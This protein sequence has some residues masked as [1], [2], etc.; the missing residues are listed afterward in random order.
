[1]IRNLFGGFV[2]VAVMLIASPAVFA[3]AGVEKDPCGDRIPADQLAAAKAT[4]NPFVGDAV[5]IAEGKEIFEG[6]GTCFTCHGLSG[7]GDGVAGGA[8]D[9]GPRNFTNLKFKDCKTDGEKLWVIENG[10]PGTGMIPAVL[11]GILTAEE[12]RKVQ[13]YENTLK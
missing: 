8:L 6:K 3:E 7:K 13:A 4:K 2:L 9:P 11:T 12:A 1:M 10:S 5:A